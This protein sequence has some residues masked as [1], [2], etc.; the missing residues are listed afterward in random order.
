LLHAI[1]LGLV[2]FGLWLL[3]SGYFV[4]LLLAL[5]VASVAIIVWIAH[6]MDVIDHEGHPIHL[7]QRVLLYWPWLIKEIVM[8]NL[9]VARAIVSRDMPVR[10]SVLKVR[11]TQKTE[12]GQVVFANSITLTPGTVTIEVDK[13]ILTVHALTRGTADDLKSGEMDR[14]VTQLEAHPDSSDPL[15]ETTEGPFQ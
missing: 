8:A 13:D 10:L 2:L 6:K 4:T 12:L 15:V 5:G 11:S 1:S 9:H 7:T 3:L 14:R